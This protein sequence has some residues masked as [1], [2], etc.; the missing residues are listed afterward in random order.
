[1]HTIWG[2][3]QK[4]EKY[5]EKLKFIE[6]IT[7]YRCQYLE[8]NIYFWRSWFLSFLEAKSEG[9]NDKGCK[10]FNQKYTKIEGNWEWSNN[11]KQMVI[12]N[13][14]KEMDHKGMCKNMNSNIE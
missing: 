6:S 14:Q 9:L 4:Q 12:Q 5:C 2:P 3:S 8:E 1:M 7:F 11:M 10:D 13:L